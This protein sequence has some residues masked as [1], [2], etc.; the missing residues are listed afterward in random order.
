MIQ[1]LLK[2][3]CLFFATAVNNFHVYISSKKYYAEKKD[4]YKPKCGKK[5]Y[6]NNHE[7]S[8]AFFIYY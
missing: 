1:L 5:V 2:P 6:A 7:M 3:C 4:D 8:A